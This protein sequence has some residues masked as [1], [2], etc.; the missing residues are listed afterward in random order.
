MARLPKWMLTIP[1]GM[2]AKVGK[3]K[4]IEPYRLQVPELGNAFAQE[5]AA[6]LLFPSFM[7]GNWYGLTLE[8]LVEAAEVELAE[9]HADINS[10][11]FKHGTSWLAGCLFELTVNGYAMRLNDGMVSYAPTPKLLLTIAKKRPHN[12]RWL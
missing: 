6:R 4:R 11:V 7:N 12:V 10:L 9:S 2:P 5:A 3:F 8:S 1:Y